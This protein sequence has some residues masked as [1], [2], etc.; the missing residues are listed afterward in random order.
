ML[1]GRQRLRLPA[2]GVGVSQE[3]LNDSRLHW[4]DMSGM[5]C[6]ASAACSASSQASVPGMVCWYVP[7]DVSSGASYADAPSSC[8][9]QAAP[10]ESHSRQ[11]C[12]SAGQ[13]VCHA[14]TAM[15]IRQAL[16]AFHNTTTGLWV[17]ADFAS[18]YSIQHYHK[19][20]MWYTTCSISHAQHDI[21]REISEACCRYSVLQSLHVA[22][23]LA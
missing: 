11:G 20:C 18:Q 21:G 3:P 22:M 5:L 8:L 23:N 2:A 10:S 14:I 17:Q 12:T 13:E 4:S 15:Q 9:C 1:P 19:A 7:C 6:S 16:H